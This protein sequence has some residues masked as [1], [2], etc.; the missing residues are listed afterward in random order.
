[1]IYAENAFNR[2]DYKTMQQSEFIRNAKTADNF[3]KNNKLKNQEDNNLFSN[4]NSNALNSKII[5]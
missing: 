3:Y 1:M 2:D 5:N 4:K